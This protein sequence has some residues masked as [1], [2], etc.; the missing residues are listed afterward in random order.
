MAWHDRAQL[1]AFATTFGVPAHASYE[2]VLDDPA[3]DIAFIASPVSELPD[4][5]IRAAEAG[6]HL[7]IGKPMAMTIADADRMVAAIERAGVLCVPFQSIGRLRVASVKERIDRGDIGDL[8]LLHQTARWSIAEDWIASG[9]PGWFADPRHVPGGALIDEG[10]YAMDLFRWLSGSDVVEV[11][12][13][14]DNLVHVELP[15]EDWGMAFFTFANGVRA[16]LE[17]SWTI[18]APR[19][20]APSPKQNAVVRLECVGTKGEIH[21]QF[22]RD[23]GRAILAAGAGGWVFERTAGDLM[24]PSPAAPLDHLIA[25]LET[26][27]TP[28]ATVHD[29]RASFAMAMAAYQS[30][31]EGRAMTL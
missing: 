31:R 25:C 8:R 17:A 28:I 30:A 22:F 3:I 16:T 2:A 29:A 11:T 12:A 24:A 26:G 21:D 1:E 13:H 6:K 9:R 20:T 4:L 15:V 19:P 23:P 7:V 18:T 27:Q 5:A 10:I 14:I